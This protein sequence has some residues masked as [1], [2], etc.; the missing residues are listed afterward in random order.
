MSYDLSLEFFVHAAPDEV[1]MLLTDPIFINEWSGGES[2]VEKKTGGQF[3]MFDGWVEGKVLKIT[4]D[5]LAY[6]W[7]PGNW[8][9]DT[10][11]SEVHYKLVSVDHGTEV[12]VTHTGL[13]TKEEMEG[14]KT[15]WDKN[16]F[17]LIAEYLSNRNQS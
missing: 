10:R 15:G 13:P 2:L 1:M 16:F 5:E 12:F 7:K 4:D 14:H 8:E 17:G 11:A 6:T 9:E 3:A